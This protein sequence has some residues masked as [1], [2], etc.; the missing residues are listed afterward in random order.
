MEQNFENA[1]P[2]RG[3]AGRDKILYITTVTIGIARFDEIHC[4]RTI[5]ISNNVF[6]VGPFYSNRIKIRSNRVYPAS[7]NIMLRKRDR[8]MR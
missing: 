4:H 3:T 2:V 1:R 6:N 8:T 5:Q 7:D